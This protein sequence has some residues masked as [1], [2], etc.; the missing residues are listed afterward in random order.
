MKFINFI[1]SLP[2]ATKVFLAISLL[3]IIYGNFAR[4]AGIYFF[5]ESTTFGWILLF[6]VAI[7]AMV[8]FIKQKKLV[9]Q[10]TTGE[11]IIVGILVFV[12]AVKSRDSLLKS[13]NLIIG[14]LY[15]SPFF[16]FNNHLSHLHYV[17]IKAIESGFDSIA[18]LLINVHFLQLSQWMGIARYRLSLLLDYN[19]LQDN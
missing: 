7:V 13:N 11:K 18:L 9:K 2:V 16:T 10:R 12:I 8:S 5:W 3:L 15:C 19:S 14:I 17:M 1:K 4:L 6:I